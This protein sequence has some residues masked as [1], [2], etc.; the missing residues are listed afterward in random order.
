MGQ[1]DN[2]LKVGQLRMVVNRRGWYDNGFGAALKGFAVLW[3]H[4]CYFEQVGDYGSEGEHCFFYKT[5]ARKVVCRGEK[6]ADFM[7]TR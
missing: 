5:R 7:L 3:K 6:A 4:A 1:L 2:M